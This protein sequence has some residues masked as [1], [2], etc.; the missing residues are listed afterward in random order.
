MKNTEFVQKLKEI[1]WIDNIAFNKWQ[2]DN[3][4]EAQQEILSNYAEPEN[5]AGLLGLTEECFDEHDLYNFPSILNTLK[6]LSKGDFHDSDIAYLS[7]LNKNYEKAQ[8]LFDDVNSILVKNGIKKAFYI[9]P[10]T[11]QMVFYV[12]KPIEVYQKALELGLIP[13]S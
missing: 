6:N 4:E 2:Y 3:L 7:K 12:Y 13:K 1:G 8:E 10:R 5:N 9:L 11:D